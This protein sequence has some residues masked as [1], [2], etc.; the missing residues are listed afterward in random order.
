MPSIAP[1]LFDAMLREIET[2]SSTRKTCEKYSVRYGNFFEYLAANALEA[3]RY[4]R[5][6]DLGLETWADQIVELADEQ[7]I[8]EKTRETKD[9]TFTETGD[10]VE[11]SRLQ[12]ESRKWLL[13]RLKPS[14]YGDALNL[15]HSGNIG[16]K[17]LII[18][19]DDKETT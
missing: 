7:R 6:K 2:G 13:A 3:E 12:I 4:A 17:Q 18:K 19:D 8:G 16:L 15:K 5:A 14:R 1:H 10:M 9:G 11:R